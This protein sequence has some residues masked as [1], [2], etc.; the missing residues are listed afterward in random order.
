[1]LSYNGPK[2]EEM[3]Y[4][5][6]LRLILVGSFV[7]LAAAV[8]G[9]GVAI[10]WAD[11]SDSDCTQQLGTAGGT[12]PLFK[13]AV[14]PGS[15]AGAS[16]RD[17]SFYMAACRTDANG[18]VTVLEK[19]FGDNQCQD[20][21]HNWTMNKANRNCSKVI[22]GPGKNRTHVNLWHTILNLTCV[23]LD[24]SGSVVQQQPQHE[25]GQKAASLH[26]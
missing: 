19:D 22:M 10:T 23:D 9:R 12:L 6:I 24:D 17:T 26:H 14:V 11:Y 1:M 21:F 4:M 25:Q 13:C 7:Q 8:V 20:S 18:S 15:D 2:V 16:W 3:V 5:A